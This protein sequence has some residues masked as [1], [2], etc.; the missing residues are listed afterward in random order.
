MEIYMKT[1]DLEKMK[2]YE[3]V[4]YIWKSKQ[5]KTER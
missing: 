1:V 3:E 2:D 5:N 4:E